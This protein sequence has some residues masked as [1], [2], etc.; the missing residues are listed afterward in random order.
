MARRCYVV[1]ESTGRPTVRRVD[2][3]RQELLLLV[4]PGRPQWIPRAH[5][6]DTVGADNG[7]S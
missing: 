7:G 4:E 3:E 6:A 5:G 1:M 2:R